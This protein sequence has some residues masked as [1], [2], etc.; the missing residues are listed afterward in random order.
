MINLNKITSR[1]S[2]LFKRSASGLVIF[3]IHADSL[4]DQWTERLDASIRSLQPLPKR[5]RICL[6]DY[7]SRPQVSPVLLEKYSIDYFHYPVSLPFNRSWSI[8]FAYKK[9]KKRPDRFLIFT[10]MD[11]I[12]PPGFW[13]DALAI[14]GESRGIV[15][16]NV[17]YMHENDSKCDLSYNELYDRIEAS[18][19]RFYGGACLV[20]T[21]LFEHIHGFDENYVGWGAEDNDFINRIKSVGGSVSKSDTLEVL[22]LDHP[23][24]GE[25]NKELVNRNRERLACKERGEISMIGIEPWGEPLKAN[26]TRS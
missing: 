25:S 12:Y 13:S 22:H 7:S 21:E 18:W 3:F 5:W 2:R 9:F 8:N 19:R 1:V 11:L 15:I 17:Y 24:V 23:R 4:D 6:G 26:Q 10:D 14:L 20:P 16:P